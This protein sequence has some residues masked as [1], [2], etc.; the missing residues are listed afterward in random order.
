MG[1][2]YDR[3]D[4]IWNT[5]YWQRQEARLSMDIANGRLPASMLN[6][7]IT[8]PSR[9][10]VKGDSGGYLN[11]EQRPARHLRLKDCFAY[12]IQKERFKL[13]RTG[14]LL[15]NLKAW[16]AIFKAC[17]NCHQE[18]SKKAKSGLKD[19]PCSAHEEGYLKAKSDVWWAG[20]HNVEER[21]ARGQIRAQGIVTAQEAVEGLVAST[22]TENP[23]NKWE[24]AYQRD[25][26]QQAWTADDARI[27]EVEPNYK[28]WLRMMLE[29]EEMSEGEYLD[30]LGRLRNEAIELEFTTK[31]L[32]GT[33]AKFKRDSRHNQLG[34]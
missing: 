29:N 31:A 28:G 30:E 7:V 18:V 21:L 4:L 9:P 13:L 14:M 25:K 20:E 17:P 1:K 8:Y 27:Y 26:A 3:Q 34:T 5:L 19:V 2:L 22:F 23:L 33:N 16:A 15:S 11:D 12:E 32:A 6:D 10:R 24:S